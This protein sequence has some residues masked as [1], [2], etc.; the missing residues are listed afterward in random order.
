MSK[1]PCMQFQINWILI[2]KAIEPYYMHAHNYVLRVVGSTLLYTIIGW[3]SY[4]SSKSCGAHFLFSW[5]H[6]QIVSISLVFLL[7]SVLVILMYYFLLHKFS[8]HCIIFFFADLF[9]LAV[10]VFH[11][12]SEE[13]VLNQ[14]SC[15]VFT[16]SYWCRGCCFKVV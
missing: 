15:W 9:S 11:S 5:I 2:M 16:S 7:T 1:I 13:K 12:Y 14:P 3:N 8:K 4:R 6:F 10:N